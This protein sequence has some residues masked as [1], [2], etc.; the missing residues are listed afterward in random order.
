MLVAGSS[1][2]RGGGVSPATPCVT[3]AG[4]ETAP[5]SEGVASLSSLAFMV[6]EI[7]RK[8]ELLE[9]F[10]GEKIGNCTYMVNDRMSLKIKAETL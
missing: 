5:A 10:I 2:D 9:S 4:G 7:S 6:I 1:E 8:I 3:V